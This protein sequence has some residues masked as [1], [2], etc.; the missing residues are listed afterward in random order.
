VFYEWIWQAVRPRCRRAH[1]IDRDLIATTLYQFKLQARP[2]L[3]QRMGDKTFDGS[4][5][6]TENQVHYLHQSTSDE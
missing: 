3:F 1:A 4:S 2:I 5:P 6:N